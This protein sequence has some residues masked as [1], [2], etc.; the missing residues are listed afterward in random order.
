M[1][2][3]EIGQNIKNRRNELGMT[4]E[5]LAK[6]MHTTRQ[7][8]SSWEQDRTQPSIDMIVELSKVLDCDSQSLMDISTGELNIEIIESKMRNFDE[9]ALIRIKKYAEYLISR[10]N[11]EV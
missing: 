4:Q 8:I 6:K 3:K 2:K 9:Y 1:L 10:N 5:E 7:C 11:T